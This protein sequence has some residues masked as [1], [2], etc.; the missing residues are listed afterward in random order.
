MTS[1]KYDLVII[2]SG[3]AGL[4]ALEAA[5][6]AGAGR[7][8]IVESERRLGG[9]CPNW[10]CMPTKSLLQTVDIL[11]HCG[12]GA[13][14]G[15]PNCGGRTDFSAARKRQRQVIDY[16][17]A[18]PRLSNHVRKLGADLI[19]GRAEF[20]GP[21]D[22]AVGGRRY[23]AGKFVVCAGS[24][25]L[26]PAIPGLDRVGY[27]TV[28]SALDLERA[29]LS[30]LFVGGGPVGVEFARIFSVFG[31]ACTVVEAGPH[32][33]P[34]EDRDVAAVVSESLRRLGVSLMPSARAV[35]FGRRDGRIVAEVEP[36]G[37][38]K[39]REIPVDAVMVSAGKRSPWEGL[40]AAMAGI[41]LDSRGYPVLDGFLRTSNRN[42]YAAGDC[43][44]RMAFTSVAH[45]EGRAAG[46]NAIRGN[47]MKVDLRVVPHGI[48]GDPE[49][50]SVGLTEDQAKAAGYRVAVGL[51]P[52]GVLSK[53][54]VTGEPLG[55]VK[56]VCDRKTREIIGGHVAGHSASEIVHILALA[57]RARLKC[58]D[59]ADMTYAFPTYSEAVG[60]AAGNVG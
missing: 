55:L 33:L 19:R 15:V 40:G 2:G 44:G 9:E 6:E 29:P 37:G 12:R 36:V 3:P 42:V 21:Q 47:R 20:V 60:L 5:A 30:V 26:V 24:E 52:F 53:S 48:Y 8:A 51:A 57:M 25:T 32:V 34:K 35:G 11:E 22:V 10:G 41:R 27:L 23:R 49:V 58:T 39:R 14:F 18:G 4:A 45:R 59:L 38:G 56:I 7:V 16:L 13:E 17:T 28:R 50:G 46:R 31:T 54:I 43:A 1:E